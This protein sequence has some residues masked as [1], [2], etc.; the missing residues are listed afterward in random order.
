MKRSSFVKP[1]ST[2][3]K[4]RTYQAHTHC[5]SVSTD[6]HL[7]LRFQYSL[8]LFTS[9]WMYNSFWA[10]FSVSLLLQIDYIL[11]VFLKYCIAVPTEY[12]ILFSTFLE[13]RK[14]N[15]SVRPNT[16]VFVYALIACAWTS[17]I[18]Y[19][20]TPRTLISVYAHLSSL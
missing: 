9:K 12:F 11:T 17:D 2:L 15:L 18:S 4:R 13:L 19:K 20:S 5:N 10:S 7:L 14:Y 6:Y 3:K 8:S 1:R 16:A